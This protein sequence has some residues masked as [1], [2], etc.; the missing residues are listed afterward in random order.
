MLSTSVFVQLNLSTLY[1][2]SATCLLTW[3]VRHLPVPV[4]LHSHQFNIGLFV[5]G[6]LC[7][8]LIGSCL[9]ELKWRDGSRLAVNKTALNSM[10]ILY[11]LHFVG[12]CGKS[13]SLL[14]IEILVT[15]LFAQPHPTPLHYEC[16]HTSNCHLERQL[17]TCRP[18]TPKNPLIPGLAKTKTY[19]SPCQPWE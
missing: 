3:R 7:V 4:G 17:S 13:F 11:E 19:G 12:A 16:T 8:N 1:V 10:K 2:N 14:Y 5:S 15:V 18:E 6:V 9:V